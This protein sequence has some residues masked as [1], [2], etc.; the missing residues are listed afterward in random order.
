MKSR[1]GLQ[2]NEHRKE[3]AC[4][5]TRHGSRRYR[6]GRDAGPYLHQIAKLF[7][8]LKLDAVMIGNVATSIQGAPVTAPP[9]LPGG[10]DVSGNRRNRWR[11]AGRPQALTI[12][13]TLEDTYAKA[14]ATEKAKTS[15]P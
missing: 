8:E 5:D 13:V 2:Q 12:L 14:K 3:C 9:L 4:H 11:A 1:I 6:K 10:A 15:Q 7:N